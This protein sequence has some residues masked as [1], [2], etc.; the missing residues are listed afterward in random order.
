MSLI[1][2]KRNDSDHIP[3]IFRP[4]S[5]HFSS[6]NGRKIVGIWSRNPGGCPDPKL[7]V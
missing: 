6:E 5:D 7:R 1:L 4:I 3:T 2:Q